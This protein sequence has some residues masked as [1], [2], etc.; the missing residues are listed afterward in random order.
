M[1]NN[2]IE[3]MI[4]TWGIC[5]SLLS[6]HLSNWRRIQCEFHWCV[7]T[8]HSR[9]PKKW[10]EDT[11]KDWPPVSQVL[12]ETTHNDVALLAWCYKYNK[13]KVCCFV[14]SKGAR[15]TEPGRCYKAKRQDDNGNTMAR[16]VQC[17]RVISK[18]FSDSNVIVISNQACQFE[19]RIGSL[20]IVASDFL[21]HLE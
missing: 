17:L 11:R 16:D 20:M 3:L 1:R 2:K 10:P 15:R 21:W 14:F 4:H 7:K 19:L 12:L 6:T 5:G 13:C 9:Y 8:N 18:N